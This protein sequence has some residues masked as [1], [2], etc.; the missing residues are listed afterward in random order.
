MR[1][2]IECVRYY[3]L[4]DV[5]RKDE[6]I[7]AR[8]GAPSVAVDSPD[9]SPLVSAQSIDE[10]C[11]LKKYNKEADYMITKPSDVQYSSSGSR[12]SVDC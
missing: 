12:L 6:A 8:G 7:R 4:H 3:C 10:P 2:A 1:G 9:Y 5:V 11:L